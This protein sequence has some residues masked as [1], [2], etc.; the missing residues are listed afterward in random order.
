MR[1]KYAEEL[2]KSTTPGY[3]KIANPIAKRLQ[4][5][6]EITRR[7]YEI[8]RNLSIQ[9]KKAVVLLKFWLVL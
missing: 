7:K 6:D 9:I 5:Y 4:K 2:T 1:K 8:K 3:E